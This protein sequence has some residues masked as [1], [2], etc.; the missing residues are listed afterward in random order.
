ME[1]ETSYRIWS[2]LHSFPER[3]RPRLLTLAAAFV[4]CAVL[5]TPSIWM[6]SMIPPLWRD[7][8]AYVQVTRPPG[9]ETILQYGPLYCFVAR[10]PLYVGYTIDLL[11]AGASLPAP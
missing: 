8:D 9:P 1:E 6:L 7:V 2:K 4:V 11:R 10:V 3:K 5:L